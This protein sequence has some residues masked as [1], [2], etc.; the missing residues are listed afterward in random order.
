MTQEQFIKI[1]ND[2]VGDHYEHSDLFM[3]YHLNINEGSTVKEAREFAKILKEY[4]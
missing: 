1:F 4:I 3:D 2:I